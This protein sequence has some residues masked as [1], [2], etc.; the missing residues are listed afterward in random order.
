MR[1]IFLFLFITIISLA[2]CKKSELAKPAENPS[3]TFALDYMEV[4]ENL[5]GAYLYLYGN[6][7]DSSAGSKV[8][9]GNTIIDMTA[10]AD[11]VILSW[12]S[13]YI[14]VSIGDPNDDAGAGFV[15]VF[16]N[17]KETNKRMLNVWEISMLYKEPDE[18]SILKEVRFNAFLRADAHPHRNILT[19]SRPST[20]SSRSQAFWAIGGQ[21]YAAYTGGGNTISLEDR[22]GIVI[23][24]KPYEDHTNAN[25]NFQSEVTFK[26]GVFK[27]SGLRMHKL[28]A[29][30]I[31][32]L[33]DGSPAPFISDYD[34]RVEVLPMNDTLK[35]ELDN[36]R[37]IKAGSLVTGPHGTQYD[38][39][40]DGSEA[41]N[42]MH[43]F[44][45]QWEKVAPRF[46]Q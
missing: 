6:F 15:S 36:D 19:F 3:S 41:G 32:N 42:H 7:G 18:G 31:S 46:Q 35:L 43:N 26:D 22:S 21:G 10:Q 17:G 28:D 1:N 11:G 5:F 29:T 16:N 33:A 2:S 13:F 44:T 24:N 25:H 37:A 4:E 30:R 8:K 20:F 34:F 23:W 9:I 39:T 45:L 27:I 38:F 40:W 14:K 12:T